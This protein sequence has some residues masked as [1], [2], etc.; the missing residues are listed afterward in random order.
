MITT[1]S[2]KSFTSFFIINPTKEYNN[3][4]IIMHDT[5]LYVTPQRC[6]ISPYTQVEIVVGL[7]KPIDNNTA[8]WFPHTW[9]ETLTVKYYTSDPIYSSFEIVQVSIQGNGSTPIKPTVYYNNDS[10]S[11]ILNSMNFLFSPTLIGFNHLN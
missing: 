5:S 2:I 3:I 11:L 8:K 1:D 6:K 10:T 4:E 9:T 7:V